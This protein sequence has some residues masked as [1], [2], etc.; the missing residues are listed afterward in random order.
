MRALAAALLVA[1][2]LPTSPLALAREGGAVLAID[3]L[4]A[5]LLFDASRSDGGLV[6]VTLRWTKSPPA[7]GTATPPPGWDL[8]R[9]LWT[10]ST[11]DAQNHTMRT[12]DVTYY[13]GDAVLG[14]FERTVTDTSG[15]PQTADSMQTYDAP[16]PLFPDPPAKDA[17]LHRRCDYSYTRAYVAQ[18][19]RSWVDE[20]VTSSGPVSLELPAG[21]FGAI[22]FTSRGE[23]YTHVE[24]IVDGCGPVAWRDDFGGTWLDVKLRSGCAPSAPPST[25]RPPFVRCN[26]AAP[27]YELNAQ[28]RGEIVELILYD[29]SDPDGDTLVVRLLDGAGHGVASE[30][31]GNA[32]AVSGPTLQIPRP[33][34]VVANDGLATAFSDCP[35]PRLEGSTSWR[36][37]AGGA[38]ES[39][40]NDP[41]APRHANAPGPD[42]WSE[43]GRWSYFDA[44]DSRYALHLL[45]PE[46]VA[47][48]AKDGA[49]GLMRY[50]RVRCAG[51]DLSWT[52]Y[53][54]TCQAQVES[55]S[56]PAFPPWRDEDATPFAWSSEVLG[57]ENVTVPAGTFTALV[58][59]TRD[60]REGATLTHWVVPDGCGDVKVQRSENGTSTTKVAA[61]RT[62]SV[63]A[64][65]VGAAP[66]VAP[67]TATPTPAPSSASPDAGAAKPAPGAGFAGL[68]VAL[69]G[70]A[71]LARR[72]K[73][74]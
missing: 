22:T 70:A 36:D 55:L 41:A 62:C 12:L 19:F 49:P 23:G 1:L 15:T 4:D 71:L 26:H 47:A 38:T 65:V 56:E 31:R 37:E 17:V 44:N 63:Q 72:S 59:R 18:P 46:G 61:T 68:A 52:G 9:L 16:C 73:R 34:R 30:D 64:R 6:D 74:S 57:V 25:N 42:Q 32:F 7:P 60:A 48:R 29:A 35:S 20:N 40:V 54:T 14:Q 69:L 3:T 67:S 21:R 43:D 24:S 66:A 58:V 50:E 11:L 2:L 39:G 5:D 8:A 27:T 33:W 51:L 13:A 28:G 53:N 45:P 10:N